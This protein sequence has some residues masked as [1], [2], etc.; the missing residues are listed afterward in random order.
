MDPNR[1]HCFAFDSPI[2]RLHVG[3]RPA[4]PVV[5]GIYFSLPP[6][7]FQAPLSAGL[8]FSSPPSPVNCIIALLSAYFEGRPIAPPWDLLALAPFS[9]LQ[10]AV[11]QKTADIAFGTFSTYKALA[12]KIGRPGACRFVGNAL[13]KN[14]YPIIIPCHRVIRSDGGLGGF[15]S[16]LDVKKQLLEFEQIRTGS[17]PCTCG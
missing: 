14:P 5:T 6:S 12:A 9:A 3:Y 4:D 7:A 1:E 17:N 16:G 11:W 8:V 10:R 15:G 2:G 13:G